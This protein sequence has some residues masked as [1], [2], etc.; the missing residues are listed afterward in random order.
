MPDVN[1]SGYNPI[2]L[3]PESFKNMQLDA[4]AFFVGIDTSAIK[5]DPATKKVGMTAEQFAEI[6][7]TA[8]AENKALGATVGGGSFQATPEVRQIEADGM[9]SPIVGS[10]VFDAWEGKL[11]TTL[12]EITPGNLAYTLATSEVDPESGAIVINNT[13]LP[14][15]YIKTMGWAGRLLDGRL[16]YIE[17]QNALNIVGTNLTF[18]DKGEGTIAVEYRAHQADLDKMQYAPVKIFF[19]DKAPAPAPEPEPEP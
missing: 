4:G 3:T 10:T 9:R 17:I 18:T 7:K 14:E 19:F 13:L 6:L 12:K 2:G 11:T 5:I 15:H 8:V 16:L 1:V